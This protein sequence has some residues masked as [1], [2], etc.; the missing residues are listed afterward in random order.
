[1]KISKWPKSFGD[2]FKINPNRNHELTL[3]NNVVQVGQYHHH[4][5]KSHSR[6]NNRPME[7]I[8]TK[9]TNFMSLILLLL[10]SFT[11][12]AQVAED[13]DLF[14]DLRKQDSLLFERGF[15]QCDTAYLKAHISDDLRFYHDQAGIQDRTAFLE[16][17]RK[18][19]C[20]NFELKPIRKVDTNSLEVFPLYN[21]GMIYGAI[22]KGIHHFN[23][24]EK[25]KD[26]V[27][28]STA[29]FTHVWILDNKIWKICEVLSYDHQDPVVEIIQK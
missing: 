7:I 28:T 11:T 27:G 13:S 12:E 20:S 15:N 22:Q 16:N 21:N 18:Y 4:K 25:G 10:I 19:L 17:T 29:R 5:R 8:N 9:I 1:M 14:I 24:R 2:S 23:L 26:D 6:Y 3:N